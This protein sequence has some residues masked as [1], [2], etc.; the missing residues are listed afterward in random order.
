MSLARAPV[1]MMAWKCSGSGVPASA[2]ASPLGSHNS[3]TCMR[4][5]VS[6]PVLSAHNIDAAPSVS[7]AAALRVN[8]PARP[9]RQAPMARN[10]VST[11]GNSSGSIAMP[12][13]MPAKMASSQPPRSSPYSSTTASATPPPPMPHSKTMR[14]ISRRRRGASRSSV[15]SEAPMRPISL[16]APVAVTMA[17]PLPRTTSVPEK[18]QGCPSP[19]GRL[20]SVVAPGRLAAL[21]TGTDS[22]VSIASSICNSLAST[23]RASA[24]TRS[25]CSTTRRSPVTTS[26]PAIRCRS[27]S[28]TTSARG[29]DRSRSATSTRSVRA[30]WTMLMMTEKVAKISRITA[31]I[32]SPS[33]R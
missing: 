27:P 13:A 15:A 18:T 3:T 14:V 12:T 9:I 11:T 30:C 28:R 24:A 1:L 4:F 33:N 20:V 25:P 2:V 16:R 8:T 10:T 6:V 32:R 17:R 5:W 22:P 31:S 7:I 21:L 26:R 23:N 19:P 29:A